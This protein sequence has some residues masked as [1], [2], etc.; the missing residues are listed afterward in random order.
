[1]Q[2]EENLVKSTTERPNSIKIN[3]RNLTDIVFSQASEG[4]I[5]VDQETK[6][7]YVNAAFTRITGYEKTEVLGEK[8]SIL[9]SGHHDQSFY[10]EMWDEIGRAGSWSGEIWDRRKNGQIYPQWLSITLIRD[11]NEQGLKYVALFWDLTAKK[12]G[13]R[14]AYLACH[15]ALTGL[16]NRSLLMERLEITLAQVQRNRKKLAVF[17]LSVDRFKYVNNT[18]GHQVGDELLKQIAGR[19][20]K[21]FRQD[22]TIAR[23]GGAE[24]ALVLTEL[25]SLEAI[26]KLAHKLQ[27]QFKLP[28]WITEKEL[29]VTLSIGIAVFPSDGKEGESLLNNADA[30]MYRAIEQGGNRTEMFT[31]QMNEMVMERLA[32]EHGLRRALARDEF[33]LFYQPQVDVTS[34]EIV[35]AEALLRWRSPEFGLMSPARF[36]PIAEETGLIIPIGEWVLK[37]AMEEAVKWREAG[38]TDLRI[39]INLSGKQFRQEHLVKRIDEMLMETG[40]D[41]H[42]LELEITESVAMND[43][44]FTVSILQDLKRRGVQIAI[45]DFGTGYSS[46]NY[47]QKLPINTLKIDS[48]FLHKQMKNEDAAIIIAI[49]HL[50]QTLNYKAVAE[51]V[52]TWEQYEFL[53]GQRCD[54]IQGYLFSRPIP[55]QEFFSFLTEKQ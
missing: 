20:T 10:L 52:E 48:T 23:I 4:I 18:L 49:L 40:L 14:T 21:T 38:Y 16:P 55:S 35:G 5:V 51:G 42:Q 2:E 43:V 39:A 27:E 25:N 13:E 46:L 8:P 32:L 15:D 1:M 17:V 50:A 31:P 53:K 37:K 29:Y 36:I 33:E 54:E 45:D 24:F 28:F 19:L 22:D 47:L 11:E 6:I 34:G 7:C 3:K 26:S 41:S 30:A 44:E 12:Q 9:S